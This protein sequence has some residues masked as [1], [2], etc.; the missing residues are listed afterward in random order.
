MDRNEISIESG[1]FAWNVWVNVTPAT[2]D[3]TLSAAFTATVT[4]ALLRDEGAFA[5]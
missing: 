5:M 3:H 1:R 2:F 4:A